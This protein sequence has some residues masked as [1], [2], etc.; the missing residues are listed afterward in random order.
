MSA[1]LLAL[2]ASS[3]EGVFGIPHGILS[4]PDE[5]LALAIA[6]VAVAVAWLYDGELD[7]APVRTAAIVGIAVSLALS[8]IAPAA[9]TDEWHIPVI[10][11]L[12]IFGGAAALFRR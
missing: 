4:S 7:L 3:N 12:L 5:W 2:A 8:V 11:V 6:L 9:V 1:E 10:V